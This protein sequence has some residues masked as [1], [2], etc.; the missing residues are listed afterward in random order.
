MCP[1][2]HV[3]TKYPHNNCTPQHTHTHTYVRMC[4]LSVCPVVGTTVAVRG[5]VVALYHVRVSLQCCG[6]Q[7]GVNR[8]GGGGVLCPVGGVARV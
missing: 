8:G 4:A 1:I 2:D 3:I 5:H 7:G 6:G